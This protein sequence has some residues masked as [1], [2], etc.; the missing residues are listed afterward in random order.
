MEI[1]YWQSRWQKKNTGWHMQQV[2]P[3]LITHWDKLDLDKGSTVLVPLCGKSLDMLW[4]AERDYKVI[5]VEVSDVAILEFIDE[6]KKPFRATSKGPFT[7]HATHSIQLWQGDF[8]K[9]EPPL[10]PPVDAIYDK[11]A[12]VALPEEKRKTYAARILQLCQA[13]TQIFLSSFEYEQ[14]EMSGPPFSVTDAEIEKLYGNRF[15]IQL[16]HEASLL[17]NVPNFRQRGLHSYLTEK[18]YR[19]SPKAGG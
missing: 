17:Q 3:H 5:G 7:V 12:L 10:V 1:S 11:A 8:F 2:Y 15:D 6:S 16:L 4:L 13:H 18:V 14:K 9:L 19:L